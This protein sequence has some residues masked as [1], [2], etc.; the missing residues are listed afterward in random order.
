[1][2]VVGHVVELRDPVAGLTTVLRRGVRCHGGCP[3]K[4]ARFVRD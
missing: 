3:L 1:M 2:L 4:V